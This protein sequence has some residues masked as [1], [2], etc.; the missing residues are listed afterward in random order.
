[1]DPASFA[2]T[3]LAAS[4]LRDV[5]SDTYKAV[6]T[7]LVETFGLGPAMNALEEDPT[8]ID[9]RNFLESKLSRSGAIEDATIVEGIG[10]IAAEL[11][12]LPDDT[13]IVAQLTVRDIKAHAAS[14]RRM[15]VH[16]GGR[17]EFSGIDVARS[18]TVEDIEVGDDRRR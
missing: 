3:T 16:G 7:K 11:E 14:F 5:A 18:L 12:K 10:V 9:N 6:K 8:D 15:K 17:A 4:L 1:M 2:I 13:P